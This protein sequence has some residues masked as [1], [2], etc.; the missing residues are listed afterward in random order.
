MGV[1]YQVI[2]SLSLSVCV[3]V[4]LSLSVSASPWYNRIGWLGVKYQVIYS[5]CVFVSVSLSLSVSLCL[6]LS[7]SYAR[8]V[9]VPLSVSL[10]LCDLHLLSIL[11]PSP[12]STAP[13]P[14]F[15]LPHSPFGLQRS[16]LHLVERR[17]LIAEIEMK[18][19]TVPT[20]KPAFLTAFR[21]TFLLSMERVNHS[22]RL[23]GSTSTALL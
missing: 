8:S 10:C 12:W 16:P 18:N 2:Y 17:W 5:L 4:S 13:S 19:P 14:S 11:C 3:S 21:V 9:S 22:W 20:A 7:V 15:S 23:H 6:C 1:K